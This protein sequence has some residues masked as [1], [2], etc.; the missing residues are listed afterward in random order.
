MNWS[1]LSQRLDSPSTLRTIR[2][3]FWVFGVAAGLVLTYTTRY[4][5]NGDAPAYVE[6]GEF[7]RNGVWEGLA[8]LTY[9]PLY[10]LL[11]GIAQ[12]V[13]RTDPLNEIPI[14]H[15]VNFFVFLVSMAVCE[16]ILRFVRRDWERTGPHGEKPL[17]FGLLCMCS[18]ALLLVAA[19]ISVR[20]RLLSPDMLVLALTL[21]CAATLLWV[22]E[23]PESYGRYAVMGLMVG[24]GYLAKSFFF[25][26]SPV[27]FF[28]GALM[29][30]SLRKAAART[31][32]AVLA[33]L[34]VASPLM[35]ALSHR[36]GRFS[37]GELGGLAYALWVSGDTSST[38]GPEVIHERPLVRIYRYPLPCAQP[39][40]H[41]ICFWHKGV[42][43]ILNPAAHVGLAV[44]NAKELFSA[45]P[46]LALFPIWIAFVLFWG[47]FRLSPW[48]PPSAALT[49]ITPG[50]LGCAFYFLIRVEP[51]Y[52]ASFIFLLFVGCAT[53][54][55]FPAGERYPAKTLAIA[56][57]VLTLLMCCLLIHTVIDQSAAGLKGSAGKPS[58][59]DAYKERIAVK[60]F[61]EAHGVSPGDAAAVIERRPPIY[62]A[63][64][65][66]I[67]IVGE[68]PDLQDFLGSAPQDRRLALKALARENVRAVVGK[69]AALRGLE[70]EGWRFIPGAKDFF[71][72]I[73]PDEFF[74][75]RFAP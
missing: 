45:A 74:D 29:A 15:W 35:A 59:L 60:E 22:R 69:N 30:G 9:S 23:K 13:L 25:C 73:I 6:M 72:C 62:W 2:A 48:V 19:L 70:E 68:I 44:Q 37:Y 49:L 10:P 63:R 20:P 39:S 33:A 11:L 41:D 57:S 12:A 24:F 14:L 52:L 51:R 4:Y 16:L 55:R 34:L 42:R 21:A 64:M 8:N 50:V 17:S 47:G 65:L 7:F 32:V 43:P 53:G 61:L 58:Y 1:A 75:K 56:A 67:S 26:F 3:T 27:F 46:W 31:L 66:R 40:G 5:I 18:Y 36:M 71:A 28:M 54:L 38:S